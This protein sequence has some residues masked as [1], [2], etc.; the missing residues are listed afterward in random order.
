MAKVFRGFYGRETFGLALVLPAALEQRD[1]LWEKTA[2]NLFAV[3]L[4][5]RSNVL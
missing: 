1:M 5:L 3:F 2:N 4:F